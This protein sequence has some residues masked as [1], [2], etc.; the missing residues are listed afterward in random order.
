MIVCIG[1]AVIDMIQTSVPGMGE[2]FVPLPGGCA[3]NTSITIGRLETPVAFLGRISTNFF[4]EIQVT[5]LRESHVKDNLLIRCPE[6]PVLSFIKVEEGKEPLYAFYEDGTSDRLLS[7]K[8]LPLQL[9][10]DTNCIVFG[11]I[12]MVM[13]PM[14]STIESFIVKEAERNVITFDPNIRPFIIKDRFAYLKRF[15]KWASVSTIVKIS[16]EDFEYIQPK[17]DPQEALAKLTSMGTRLVIIT[18]G[19][20]G[21]MAQLRRNDGSIIKV[22]APGVT[23]TNLIDTVG[24]GDTFHGAFLA[25]LDFR[26]KMSINAIADLSETDLYDALV[27]ANKAAAFVCT[28]RAAEPPT[29]QEIS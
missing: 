26:G 15:E 20:K 10:A 12:S 19:A 17:P 11:S 2:V 9:P 18:L 13:E 14:A 27:F 22:N 8:D 16:L 5:R 21:C 7:P 3:Y 24:A 1:E 25:W 29:L 6:N 23:V 4:G 28:K